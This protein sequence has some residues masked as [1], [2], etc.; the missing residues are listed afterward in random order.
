MTGRG[1]SETL[2]DSRFLMAVA[3]ATQ[4]LQAGADLWVEGCRPTLVAVHTRE[5]QAD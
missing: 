2:A 5:K 4:T 1:S 3:A